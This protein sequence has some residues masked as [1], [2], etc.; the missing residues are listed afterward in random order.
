MSAK[1]VAD[2]WKLVDDDKISGKQAKD[3]YAKIAKTNRAPGD[4]IAELGISQVTDRSQIE[5][6]CRKIIDANAKTADAIARRKTGLLR[7]FSSAK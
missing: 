3:V 4:V 7:I 5:A 1:Q 2:L 6:I